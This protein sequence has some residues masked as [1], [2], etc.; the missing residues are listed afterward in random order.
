KVMTDGNH[1]IELY[2]MTGIGHHDGLIMAY[3]PKE[4]V[5]VEADAYNPPAQPNPPPANPV[6]PYNMALV[7]NI[8]RLKLDVDR[9]IPIHYPAPRKLRVFLL[10]PQTPLLFK[11]GNV[12]ALK[13][14]VNSFT[15]S[16]ALGQNPGNGL[17]NMLTTIFTFTL[18]LAQHAFTP[19]EIAEGGRL[20]QSNCASC[21]GSAGDQVPGVALMSGKFGRATTDEDVARIIRNG[22]PGTA[23]QSF[24]FS[25]QQ[26]GTIVAYLKSISGSAP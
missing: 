14:S 11:E 15:R 18:L 19:D 5:L 12:S 24:T 22:I 8:E 21:H 10:M 6:S 25:E 16:D 20:Y 13:Q 17:I 7:S 4:K 9:L 3:L 26:A 2:H 23:M 1:V